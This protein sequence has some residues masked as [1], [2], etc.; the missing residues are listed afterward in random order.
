MSGALLAVLGWEYSGEHSV[1]SLHFNSRVG[2]VPGCTSS[3]FLIARLG[4]SRAVI[5]AVPRGEY[6]V[7]TLAG[8]CV[9][10][11]VSIGLVCENLAVSCAH[12][13]V[14]GRGTFVYNYWSY[15]NKRSKYLDADF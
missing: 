10:I 2:S 12:A 7:S 4:H 15:R 11:V 13:I 14:G 5:P 8:V 1:T 6:A 3:T 9:H